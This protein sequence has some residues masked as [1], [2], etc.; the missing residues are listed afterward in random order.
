LCLL[1]EQTATINEGLSPSQDALTW[2]HDF[3]EEY[4]NDGG[5]IRNGSDL[6]R[7]ARSNGIIE[8]AEALGIQWCRPATSDNYASA[9]TDAYHDQVKAWDDQPPSGC[10]H[11][12]MS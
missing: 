7:L 8:L 10:G 3:L 9:P 2:A 4:E 1:P 6:P 11:G 5:Q 12:T